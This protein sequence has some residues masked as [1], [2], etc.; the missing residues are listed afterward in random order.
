MRS[1]EISKSLRLLEAANKDAARGG[2]FRE[3]VQLCPLRTVEVRSRGQR[4]WYEEFCQALKEGAISPYEFSIQEIWDRFVPNGSELRREFDPRLGP[5]SGY[6]GYMEAAGAI[7]SGDFSSISGQLLYSTMMQ[8]LKAESYPFQQLIPNQPTQFSGERIP[9]IAG[10]GDVAQVVAENAEFP[11]VTTG[12]DYIDTPAT[13]KR[14]FIVP[15]TKEAI[16]F[17]RTNQLLD[18]AGAVGPALMLNKEKRAIDCVIDENTTAHRYKWRGMTYATYQTST[19]WVNQQSGK[20]LVDWTQVDAADQLFNGITDPNTGEPV[21]IDGSVLVVCPGLAQTANRIASATEI[22][23]VSPGYSTSGNPTLTKLPNP[24]GAKFR[25]MSSRQLAAR[26][27]TDTS[28]WYG[29]PA[30]LAKYMENWPITTSQA[31]A[32]NNDDFNRDIVTKF[33]CSERGQYAVVQPRAM[34]KQ[35]V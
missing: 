28:Y 15:I 13:T 12:E 30:Q 16:F 9:G 1:A 6:R 29:N 19:P 3:T 10:L 5:D 24:M 2:N 7:T 32:G 34:V 11:I 4:A 26:S 33:K 21:V 27:A 31:P 17:D 14:G 18:K 20:A 25:V 8:E 23:V 22:T 35:L